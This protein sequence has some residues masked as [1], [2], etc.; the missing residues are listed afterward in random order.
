MNHKE[1]VNS[2]Y[3]K[4]Q[5]SKVKV[6]IPVDKSGNNIVNTILSRDQ[7]VQCTLMKLNTNVA[8]E[9]RMNP[10]EI[11]SQRSKVKVTQVVGYIIFI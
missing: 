8:K 4:G 10:I 1:R 7:T 5:R 3:F 2:I 9:Q 11:G 6:T